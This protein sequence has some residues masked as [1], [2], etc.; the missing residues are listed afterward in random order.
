MTDYLLNGF[1]GRACCTVQT[2]MRFTPCFVNIVP[3]TVLRLSRVTVCIV[4]MVPV[5]FVAFFHGFVRRL[6]VCG[7]FFHCFIFVVFFQY[8]FFVCGF[9]DFAVLFAPFRY[10]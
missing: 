5:F 10:T 9:Y 3:S 4:A 2:Y 7:V 6:L 1:S 8:R